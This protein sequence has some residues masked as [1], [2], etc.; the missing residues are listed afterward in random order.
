[1]IQSEELIH[2]QLDNAQNQTTTIE[3][4]NKHT[5]CHFTVAPSWN[6]LTKD[7]FITMDEHLKLLLAITFHNI[8]KF[9]RDHGQD[10]LSWEKLLE[11][12]DQNAMIE[13]KSTTDMEVKQ[14]KRRS[15]RN[16]FKIDGKSDQILRDEVVR[17][18]RESI[19]DPELLNIIGKEA[20]DKIA[21]IYAETGAKISGFCAFFAKT[22]VQEFTLLDV[23]IIRTPDITKPWLQLFR[24]KIFVHRHNQRVLFVEDN[25]S[26][27]TLEANTRDYIPRP[28][29]MKSINPKIMAK[30]I[31]ETNKL[32]A[33][34]LGIDL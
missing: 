2:S 8:E 13:R 22:E 26:L 6:K 17:W 9:V 15:D 29:V 18:I 4:G 10:S 11:L 20:M 19:Q 1:M 16:Y 3:E 33:E 14:T 34:M 31:E 23:G 32:L 12:M 7:S 21:T 24:I 25:D 30:A 28:E 5:R 27:L